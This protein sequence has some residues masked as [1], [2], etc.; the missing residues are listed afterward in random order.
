MQS[1]LSE[2]TSGGIAVSDY[3]ANIW[4]KS[5]REN[6]QEFIDN[7]PYGRGEYS[8]F[9]HAIGG[10]KVPKYYDADW[11]YSYVSAVE[12]LQDNDSSSPGACSIRS[13]LLLL[14]TVTLAATTYS[15]F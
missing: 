9:T 6:L 10:T 1:I 13:S 15:L 11:Y 3:Y 14:A 7:Y 8:Q 2:I 5:F 4:T 12:Q